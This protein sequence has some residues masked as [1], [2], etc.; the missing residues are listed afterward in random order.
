MV[1]QQQ[2]TGTQTNQPVA[3]SFFAKHHL[4]H[5]LKHAGFKIVALALLFAVIAAVAISS[6]ASGKTETNV[7]RT[8]DPN[9][10]DLMVSSQS[11]SVSALS[12]QTTTGQ[13]ANSSNTS[14]HVTVNGQDVPVPG[15]GSVQKTITSADGS[16]T[17]NV[18]STS[19]GDSTNSSFTSTNFN[20]STN[21]SSVNNGY[22]S[23]L[24]NG[25]INYSYSY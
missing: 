22:S 11:A 17:V 15:N 25:G 14:V 16:T 12:D 10:S 4:S 21:S 6:D 18:S 19:N 24:M 9:S 13:S 7:Q 1:L 3:S 23:T 2:P 5:A 8:A 20:M